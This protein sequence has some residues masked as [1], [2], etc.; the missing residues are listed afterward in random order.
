MSIISIKKCFIALAL[1]VLMGS[2]AHATTLW[3]NCGV[4]KGLTSINAALKALQVLD[5][6][7]PATINVSGACHENVV[8]QGIDRLTLTAVNGAS[9]SDASGGT[10]DVI[11]I[12]DSRD[13]AING[14]RVTASPGPAGTNGVSCGDFST[15]RLS[16]N[17]IQGA[18]GGGFA[19]FGGSQATLNGDT[20]QNNS[21][22]GLL[23]RSAGTVRGGPFTASGN[24]QGVNIGRQAFAYVIAAI[25]NNADQGVVVQEHSTFDLTGSISGNGSVGAQVREGS[26][27]RFTTA[28]IIGNA[29]AGVLVHDL[30]MVTFSG[31]TVTGNGG[32]TDVV[33]APQFAATRGTTT[34]INGGTTNCIEQ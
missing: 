14:F 26:V 6:R 18:A 12:L 2:T 28:T 23:I 29:G 25:G 8:I 4:V 31:D 20:L 11:S 9:V 16:G 27:A 13:V 3:V 24:G 33:C 7:G 17:I 21:G 22:A 19:V 32:G 1:L 15:C 5:S 10:L 30:S 34:D